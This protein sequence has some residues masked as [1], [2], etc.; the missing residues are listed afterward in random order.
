MYMLHFFY[1]IHHP[2]I[3]WVAGITVIAVYFFGVYARKYDENE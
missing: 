2:A 1:V 3:P